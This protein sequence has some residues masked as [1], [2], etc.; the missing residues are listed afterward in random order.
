MEGDNANLLAA[1]L[2]ALVLEVVLHGFLFVF[3]RQEEIFL[4]DFFVL[5]FFLLDVSLGD[6]DKRVL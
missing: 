6:L 3:W 1:I 2:T 5:D 4:C